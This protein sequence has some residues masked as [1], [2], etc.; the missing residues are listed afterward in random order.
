M[1]KKFYIYY[2]LYFGI[3]CHITY[4][5]FGITWVI[6]NIKKN[7]INLKKNMVMRFYEGLVS[8]GGYNKLFKKNYVPNKSLK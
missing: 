3:T 4:L 2:T 7:L 6:V 8:F 1:F 5:Y